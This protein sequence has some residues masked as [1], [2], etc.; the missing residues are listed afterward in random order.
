MRP[1]LAT[2]SLL[3]A[4]CLPAATYAQLSTYNDARLLSTLNPAALGQP[5]GLS[6]GLSSVV[7]QGVNGNLLVGDVSLGVGALRVIAAHPFRFEAY[8]LGY[9]APIVTRAFTSLASLTLGA[10]AMVGYYGERH[11]KYSSYVGNGT[12]LDARVAL[13]VA[14]RLGST[15]WLSLTPYIAPYAEVGAAPMGSWMDNGTPCF[16]SFESANC[17]FLYSGHYRSHAFGTALGARLTAWRLGIDLGYGDIP[18]GYF[19]P[20]V[21]VSMAISVRF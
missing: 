16:P 9:G 17:R 7:D 13:P 19:N 5:V 21:P 15:T 20:R 14:L 2:L 3:A 11:P 1:S 10:D 6:L 18:R 8:G 4:L 12:S